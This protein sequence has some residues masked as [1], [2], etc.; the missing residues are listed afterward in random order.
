MGH[1]TRP[2]IGINTDVIP[3]TKQ[4]EA[5]LRLNVGYV[6]AILN[7]GGLP[8]IMPPFTKEEEISSFLH[9]VDGFLLTGG[10]DLDPRKIGMPMHSSIRPMPERRQDSDRLLVREL[11][12]ERTPLL[13]VGV[14][15]HQINVTLGG[16][17]IQHL[18]EEMPRCMPHWDP[19]GHG[20]HRHAVL[21]EAGTRLDEIYGEGEILVNS[22]HHQAVSQIAGSFRIAA[23]APDGVIEAIEATEPGW[24]CIGVQWQPES[25][26][27]SALDMQLFESFVQAC[28]RQHTQPLSLAA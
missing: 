27:A 13:A 26:T 24:F 23:R 15:M 22:H 18:P 12:Q 16:S 6:E 25:D 21:L 14:G 3:A 20:P 11:I 28:I 9:D 17:L 4:H 5:Q 1:L 8:V 2:V 7:A 19:S 10:L